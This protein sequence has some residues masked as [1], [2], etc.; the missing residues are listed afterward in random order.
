MTQLSNQKRKILSCASDKSLCAHGPVCISEVAFSQYSSKNAPNYSEPAIIFST[1][2]D[3][4]NS[5]DLRRLA[6]RDILQQ[7]YDPD[8][9][10]YIGD[11]GYYQV[12]ISFDQILIDGA[13]SID[14]LRN[15]LR[16]RPKLLNELI[17]ELEYNAKL[18]MA[19]DRYISKHERRVYDRII[20]IIISITDEITG[21][22]LWQY[23]SAN[24]EGWY[25][26][27]YFALITQ[28]A[29][30]PQWFCDEAIAKITT[31]LQGSFQQLR[32]KKPSF[33]HTDDLTDSCYSL[34]L[35]C[36][37]LQSDYRIGHVFPRQTPSFDDTATLLRLI[38]DNIPSKG[39]YLRAD[40]VVHTLP[41][42][43][44]AEIAYRVPARHVMT[45][46][47]RD[48]DSYAYGMLLTPQGLSFLYWF[49]GCANYLESTNHEL[50]ATIRTLLD[51]VH[52]DIIK[53]RD[54][55][56]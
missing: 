22:R 50:L 45:Y 31:V 56:S 25:A 12:G 24:Y 36:D 55:R 10:R 16:L 41:S 43:P 44:D 11:A 3:E 51:H 27:Q 7:I 37:Y 15:L 8:H 19:I 23:L 32:I 53:D 28:A 30:M 13:G 17:D 39:H 5:D 2:I 1:W 21:R 48:P 20:L 47:T 4:R 52:A 29:Q 33:A 49:Y 54:K 26:D 18:E 38:E 42:L 14:A 6:L 35:L 46:D 9:D 34:R 40:I